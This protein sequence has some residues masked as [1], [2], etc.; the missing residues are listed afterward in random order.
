MQ[1]MQKMQKVTLFVLQKSNNKTCY[2]VK[3]NFQSVAV[4]VILQYI[5]DTYSLSPICVADFPFFTK[6]FFSMFA[7]LGYDNFSQILQIFPRSGYLFASIINN[8]KN[9]KKCYF[10]I[11]FVAH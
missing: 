2:E 10:K 11:F 6:E 7:N 5:A 9:K 4:A 8:V 1:V 3:C